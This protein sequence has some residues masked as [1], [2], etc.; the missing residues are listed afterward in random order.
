MEFT[1]P[2][3]SV[4]NKTNQVTTTIQVKNVTNGNLVRLTVEEFWWDK[5]NNPVTGGKDWC[6]KPLM[7]GEVYT[8][9]IVTTKDKNMFRNNYKFSH[10][11]GEVK[12]KAVK[13][14]SE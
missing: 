12:P 3:V 8:F 6:R 7:A 13:K 11:N 10:A 9:T 14:L 5:A 4:D 2:K 1:A